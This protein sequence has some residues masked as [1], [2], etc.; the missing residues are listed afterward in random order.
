MNHVFEIID[1]SGRNI[2]LTKEQWRHIKQDH[3]EIVD[4]LSI[5]ETLE[6]PT[7]ITQPYKGTKYYY[8]KYNNG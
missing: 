1:K 3:L 2:R 5:K 4:E 8:Y 7:K 6:S